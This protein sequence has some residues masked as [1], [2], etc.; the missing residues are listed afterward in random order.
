MQRQSITEFLHEKV[1]PEIDAVAEG[2]LDH[3]KPTKLQTSGSYRLVCPACNKHEAFHLPGSHLIHC[4]RKNKCGKQTSLWDVMEAS[5]YSRKEIVERLCQLARVEPPSSSNP[6]GVAHNNAPA[7]LTPGRAIIQVTQLLARKYPKLLQDLQ[8]DRGFSDD[9]MATMRLGAYTTAEEV[10]SLLEERGI[11]K[12]VAIAKGYVLVEEHDHSKYRRA[13]N[14]RVIGYWPHPDGDVR[15][16]GRLPAGKGDQWNKKYRFADSLK[17]DVPYLFSM[18]KPGPLIAVE[19]TFDGWSIQF[20]GFWGTAIGQSSVNAAQAAHLASEGV[21]ELAHMVDGDVAGYDGGLTTIRNCE[22]AG[23]VTSIIPLGEG[24]DDPD[25]LRKAGKTA[26]FASLIDNRMNAGQ[27]L[28]RM[29]H[30]YSMESP[31]NVAGIR[32]IHALVPLLSPV[33]AKHWLDWSLTLGVGISQDTAAVRL[34]NTFINGGVEVAE[35]LD[36]VLK[37]TGIRITLTQETIHG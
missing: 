14:N 7:A 1:Y 33:S 4:P 22:P 36:L 23:I 37:R 34:L 13:M 2:L 30:A 12:D 25:A 17:K 3:L 21:T 28:A 16:W 6:E 31:P 5:G 9:Q 19:G 29:C 15:L 24:M 10:M 27:F 8:S 18:R 35:A 20:M 26:V 11:S 32:K